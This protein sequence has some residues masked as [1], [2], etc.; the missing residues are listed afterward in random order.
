VKLFGA[1]EFVIGGAMSVNLG[2]TYTGTSG[3]PLN[4][5]GSHYLYGPTEVFIL[6]RGSGGRL[7]FR[8]NIDSHLGFAYRL[9]KDSMIQLSVDVF[10]VF[11]FQGVAGKDQ[12]YTAGEAIALTK[13]NCGGRDCTA[14]D[15][16]DANG[17]GLDD[18]ATDTDG[19]PVAINP[20]FG[21][22]TAYQA[23]RSIR[24]G[25]KVTF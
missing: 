13:A 18:L 21:N 4:Y 3:S 25:A 7:P 22:P 2:L 11:N 1:K 20:N 17:D 5:M 15:L 12:I 10:N 14:A 9:S 16:G 6:P 24:F 19:D 8:H 23:P